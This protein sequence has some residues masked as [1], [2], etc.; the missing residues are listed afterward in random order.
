MTS[1]TTMGVSVAEDCTDM[2]VSQKRICIS[3]ITRNNIAPSLS[4]VY[5]KCTTIVPLTRVCGDDF[6]GESGDD[7][8]LGMDRNGMDKY[9][10]QSKKKTDELW[11]TPLEN[12]HRDGEKDEE[13]DDET[14][15][16][17][18]SDDANNRTATIQWDGILVPEIAFQNEHSRWNTATAAD[19]DVMPAVLERDVYKPSSVENASLWFSYS[20][21]TV[22]LWPPPCREISIGSYEKEDDVVSL[23]YDDPD[24][25]DEDCLPTSTI[26]VLRFC[27]DEWAEDSVDSDVD[28]E[29]DSD[30]EVD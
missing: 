13:R 24:I 10:K 9:D 28:V 29:S 15:I 1:T 23:L 2:M 18:Y 21:E 30:S 19:D 4:V 22:D 16:G 8:A 5:E 7:E 11:K 20:E 14:Y 12:D 17:T 6:K 26:D 27:L 25:D 3:K